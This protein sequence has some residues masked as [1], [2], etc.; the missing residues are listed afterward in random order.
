MQEEYQ[1]ET[2]FGVKCDKEIERTFFSG[3]LPFQ[4]EKTKQGTLYHISDGDA[5]V[6]ACV[7][8]LLTFYK[9]K[10]METILPKDNSPEYFSVL[11]ALLSIEWD[12]EREELTRKLSQENALNLDGYCLFNM[13]EIKAAWRGIAQIGYRLYNNCEND[14]DK[15]GLLLYLLDLHEKR[16]RRVCI[17]KEGLFV[18]G[19]KTDVVDMCE[20][21]E[22]NMLVNVFWHRPELIEL[23]KGY[24]ASKKVMDFLRRLSMMTISGE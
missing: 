8:V 12:T 5:F 21:Q 13:S 17:K 1:I 20:T 14:E 7:Q 24:S 6:T 22:E 10:E 9:K 4:K 18:G 16:G 19:I 11:G 3:N 23:E 15:A 2:A